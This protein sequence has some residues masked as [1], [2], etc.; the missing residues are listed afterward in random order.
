MFH[1]FRKIAGTTNMASKNRHSAR[2][3]SNGV[4]KEAIMP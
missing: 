3:K 4:D 2:T 1:K